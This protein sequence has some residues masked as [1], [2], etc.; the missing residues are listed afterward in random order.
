MRND[1]ITIS[2]GI[3]M[4]LVVLNHSCA[5]D[6]ITHWTHLFNMPLFFIMS[7]YCFKEK[8]LEDVKTYTKRRLTGL[9]V[10]YIKWCLLFLL[11][12]NA[13]CAIHLYGP[14]FGIQGIT[15]Y[16]YSLTEL[17]RRAGGIVVFLIANEE[18]LGGYWFL[19]ELFWGSF[20]FYFLMRTTR[21][22]YVVM[23]ITLCMTLLMSYF[24]FR[25][26]YFIAWR[27]A[28][29]T[30]F[31]ALGHAYR[32]LGMEIHKQW[33]FI[34]PALLVTFSASLFFT[35][36]MPECTT[37]QVFPYALLGF[38]GTLMLLGLSEKIATMAGRIRTFLVYTGEHTLEILTWHMLCFK[39]V[40][41]IF[42]LC[43]SLP[44]ARLESYPVIGLFAKQGWFL[45]YA[46]VGVG[47]PLLGCRLLDAIKKVQ[48]NRKQ[49]TQ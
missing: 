49:N 3:V 8:Y 18:L 33:K 6:A 17:A 26:S 39:L 9:Y 32:R 40:T 38:L 29:G 7:G 25:L 10:P 21:N 45:L 15:A 2:K 1:G 42:I 5:P 22:V 41:L 34:I 16:P 27:T 4:M 28:F 23:G 11:L 20:L 35:T 44:I 12:H 43:F 14:E 24:D 30:F 13:F 36:T 31:I 47:I 46:T 19:H 48:A 37:M